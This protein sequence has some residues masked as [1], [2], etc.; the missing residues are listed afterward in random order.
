MTLRQRIGALLYD[1]PGFMLRMLSGRWVAIRNRRERLTT[2]ARGARCEW[3]F[4]SDLH[5][6]KV[7]PL[8]GRWLMR[9]AL[10][11]WPIVL[12]DDASRATTEPEVSFIIGH[13]GMER[14][15]LL[16]ETLRSIAAQRDA[17]IECIV[18]EQSWTP[19]IE[20]HLPQWV[21]YVHTRTPSADFDYARSWAFNVGAR[22][23]R[24]RVLILQ[25]NDMLLPER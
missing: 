1:A 11:E 13:R 24:G 18:V 9:K 8:T 16:R 7:Y 21:R 19:E 3:R 4:T 10:R 15:P 5:I 23:A 22:L 25:D 12:S 14:L 17:S 6:A 20:A 2:D